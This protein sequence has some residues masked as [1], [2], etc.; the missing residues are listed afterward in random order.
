LVEPLDGARSGRDALVTLANIIEDH[1][2]RCEVEQIRH[3]GS[4]AY[5]LGAALF[6]RRAL[7]SKSLI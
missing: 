3:T 5:F 2:A 1:A 7:S 4:V 6:P